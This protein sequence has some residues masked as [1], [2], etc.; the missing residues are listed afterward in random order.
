MCKCVHMCQSTFL[1]I[2]RHRLPLS[3][4]RRAMSPAAPHGFKQKLCFYI[5]ACVVCQ[6]INKSDYP[7]HFLYDTLS[8]CY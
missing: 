7:K 2:H 8:K 1:Q 3:L 6:N 4:N 5:L